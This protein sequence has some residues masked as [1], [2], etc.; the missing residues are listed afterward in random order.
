MN[1]CT[2]TLA[3]TLLLMMKPAP[4]AGA[5]G[6]I[7]LFNGRDLTGWRATENPATWRVEDGEL[8]GHGDRSHLFYVGDVAGAEFGDFEWECEV[9][10][11]PGSNSGM[12]FHT[13]VQEEG[14]PDRGYEVQLNNT[15]GDP[16]KTGGLYDVADVLDDS[17]A[18]DDEWFTQRVVVRGATVEVYVN[19]ELVTSYTEPDDES[20]KPK[21]P[22]RRLSSGTIALQGHDPGSEAR[23]RSVRVKPLD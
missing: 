20:Q 3:L 17:P 22:G 12:Y 13:A 21:R 2:A 15:H 19:D 16:R 18:A 9:L 8:V 23:F 1:R 4:A 10:L 7:E 14:W 11:R 6:W 5:D